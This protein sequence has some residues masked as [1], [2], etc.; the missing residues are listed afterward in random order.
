ML[1]KK[2]RFGFIP[3]VFILFILSISLLNMVNIY[4]DKP[5]IASEYSSSWLMG[6][7]ILA[8]VLE[9]LYL[10]LDKYLSAVFE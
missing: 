8:A 3:L 4:K 10:I 5:I 1:N 2:G 9:F 7:I 6:M